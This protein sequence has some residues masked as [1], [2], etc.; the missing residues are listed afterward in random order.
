MG[1]VIKINNGIGH[2]IDISGGI[3]MGGGLKI[4]M[5]GDLM[6]SD[7]LTLD[8]PPLRYHWRIDVMMVCID[9]ARL[10]CIYHMSLLIHMI[11]DVHYC[12]SSM[13]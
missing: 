9:R 13:T 8:P 1:S 2:G 6:K 7:L 11:D 12:H 4:G 5:G 3:E 10:M